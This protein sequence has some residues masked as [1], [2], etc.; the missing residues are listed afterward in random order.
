M[1][2]VHAHTALSALTAKASAVDQ[3]AISGLPCA[4]VIVDDVSWLDS[5]KTTVTPNKRGR[6]KVWIPSRAAPTTI[7]YADRVNK[8]A[9]L[10]WLLDLHMQTQQ[11][12][13]L[14]AKCRQSTGVQDLQKCSHG[15]YT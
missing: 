12:P 3:A 10:H 14:Q 8:Q 6:S 15:S 9:P 7:L 5:G 11:I 13:S 2:C 4:C 1:V